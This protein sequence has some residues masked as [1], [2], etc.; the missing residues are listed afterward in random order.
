MYDTRPV[1]CTSE[2]DVLYALELMKEHQ[3]RRLPVVNMKREVVGILALG[4]LLRQNAVASGEIAAA[5]QRICEPGHGA[6][7]SI[8]EIVTAA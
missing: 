2:D 3:V 6:R 5:L 7:M 4:D 8:T 1:C